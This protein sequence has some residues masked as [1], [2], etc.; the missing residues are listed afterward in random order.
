[1]Q[2]SSPSLLSEAIFFDSISITF[3]VVRADSILLTL[4]RVTWLALIITWN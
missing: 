1:M 3:L 2:K 4:H